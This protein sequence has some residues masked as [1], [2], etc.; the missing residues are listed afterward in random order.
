M[1]FRSNVKISNLRLHR[2]IQ[3]PPQ[4]LFDI[5]KMLTPSFLAP[6]KK[7]IGWKII[8]SAKL[9]INQNKKR[10]PI[11]ESLDKKI[12]MILSQEFDDLSLLIKKDL[13]CWK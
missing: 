6:I 10:K 5:A 2:L 12:R 9:L 4:A 8:D 1:L 3:K 7:K 13:S 11:S